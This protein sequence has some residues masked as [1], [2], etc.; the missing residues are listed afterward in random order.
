MFLR[1]LKCRFCYLEGEDWVF[2]QWTEKNKPYCQ[3]PRCGHKQFECRWSI[4]DDIKNE[5]EDDKEEL[6][7]KKLKH[8]K[9]SSKFGPG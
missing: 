6:I 3:C 7:I 2:V 5:E 8:V 1:I 4:E 9:T